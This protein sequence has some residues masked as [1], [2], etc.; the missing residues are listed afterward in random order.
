MFRLSDPKNAIL[1]VLVLWLLMF[2]IPV[3]VAF[4]EGPTYWATLVVGVSFSDTIEVLLSSLVLTI[5]LNYV[6]MEKPYP[7][8]FDVTLCDI[9]GFY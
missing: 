6:A 3:F 8:I 5:M 4:P 9:G 1:S 7:S 2:S